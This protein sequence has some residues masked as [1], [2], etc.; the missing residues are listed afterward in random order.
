M[1][2][3]DPAQLQAVRDAI[4]DVLAGEMIPEQDPQVLEWLF[5]A[6]LPAEG[7]K[8]KHSRPTPRSHSR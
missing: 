5:T 4:E 7:P 6:P 2:V 3:N 8:A 1:V